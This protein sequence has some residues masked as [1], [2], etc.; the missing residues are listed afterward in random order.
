MA[1]NPEYE[2]IGKAFTNQYYAMFDDPIQRPN[3]INLYNAE[4]SLM[5]FEGQQL[6]GAH[7]IMEK[8]N[9][10]SFQKIQHI[11][12]VVDCQPMF[13]GGVLVNVIGQLKTDEDPPHSFAQTFVLK[14]MEQSFYLQHDVFRLAIHN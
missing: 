3:L 1:L 4:L 7:K 6:Q 14:P 11:V 9:S 8:F 10:L 12:T 13:D 5:S 2:A